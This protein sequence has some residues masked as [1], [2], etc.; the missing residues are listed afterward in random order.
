MVA[1]IVASVTCRDFPS[2]VVAMSTDAVAIRSLVLCSLFASWIFCPLLFLAVGAGM[3][4][5][6]CAQQANCRVEQQ[7]AESSNSTDEAKTD[8]KL[9]RTNRLGNLFRKIKLWMPTH[10]IRHLA[11]IITHDEHGNQTILSG[12]KKSCSCCS[13]E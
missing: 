7:I 1:G 11:G 2:L 9:N 10:R 8:N 4:P 6:A 3:S 5:R 13:L 12:N